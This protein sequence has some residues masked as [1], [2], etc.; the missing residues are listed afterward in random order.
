MASVVCW[1][2]IVLG[3]IIP[4]I[5]LVDTQKGFK[6]LIAPHVFLGSIAA[7]Q[8]YLVGERAKIADFFTKARAGKIFNMY[9][10]TLARYFQLNP[11]PKQITIIHMAAQFGLA[12]LEQAE[13]APIAVVR[14]DAGN[15]SAVKT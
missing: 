14:V 7:V 4:A 5:E 10:L 11:L 9:H 13:Q 3:F 15:S 8:D 12:A 2:P 6:P 1:L